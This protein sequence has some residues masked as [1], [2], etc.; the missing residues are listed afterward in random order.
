MAYIEL[1]DREGEFRQSR[2][3]DYPYAVAK[4]LVPPPL[5]PIETPEDLAIAS[6]ISPSTS[7][8]V[9]VNR[10]HFLK[11]YV[12]D[13]LTYYPKFTRSTTKIPSYLKPERVVVKKTGIKIGDTV[14]I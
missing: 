5:S 8:K 13:H 7:N 2:A 14:R 1:V 6:A 10:C 12:P 4:G 11:G 3:V 9:T